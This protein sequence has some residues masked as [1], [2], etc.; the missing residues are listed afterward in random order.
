M[1]RVRTPGR[2]AA[3]AVR[4]SA[5]PRLARVPIHRQLRTGH[6]DTVVLYGVPTNGW[7][8]V[9]LA[10]RAGVPVLFRAIDVSHLLSNVRVGALIERAER[11][12]Y[13]S[14]DAMSTHNDALRRYC[15]ANGATADRVSIEYPAWTCSGPGPGTPTWPRAWGSSPTTR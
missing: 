11:F 8:T 14:A 13:R 1:V 6:F 12:I 3:A 7:Q 10:R 9:H 5:R 4:P 2:R 15:I